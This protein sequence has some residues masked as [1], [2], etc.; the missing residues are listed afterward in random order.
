MKTPR[1]LLKMTIA[2]VRN[3]VPVFTSPDDWRT[4]AE[5]LAG[6]SVV[7][8]LLGLLLVD[9]RAKR[10]ARR[11]I[12][13]GMTPQRRIRGYPEWAG[14]R[15]AQQQGKSRR[16]RPPCASLSLRYIGR[17]CCTLCAVKGP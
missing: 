6:A 11:H 14:F 3:G 8:M 13:I 9:Q 7:D 15:S 1:P 17:W 12:S 10:P 4:N 5:L 2:A 16:A